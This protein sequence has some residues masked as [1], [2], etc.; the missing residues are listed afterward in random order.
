MGT[1]WSLDKPAGFGTNPVISRPD[2]IKPKV[3]T[4]LLN[5]PPITLPVTVPVPK[6]KPDTVKPKPDTVRC[7][8][9]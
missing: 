4:S 7:C 9:N 1:V 5:V 3:D 2:T 6:I 8:R